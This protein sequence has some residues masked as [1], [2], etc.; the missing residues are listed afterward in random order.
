MWSPRGRHLPLVGARS[1][2]TASTCSEPWC[3]PRRLRQAAQ[4]G[5]SGAPVGAPCGAGGARI[6]RPERCMLT[7]RG[8]RDGSTASVPCSGRQSSPGTVAS[9]YGT[10][11]AGAAE[12]G[13]EVPSTL[14]VP[15]GRQH[16][17]PL[18]IGARFDP[19]C[20]LTPEVVMEIVVV[21]RHTEVQDR[22]RKHAAEKLS[23]VAQL[24]PYAQRIDVEVT[25]GGK[26]RLCD[27]AERVELTVKAKGPVVRAEASAQDRYA[28]LDLATGKLLERLRRARDRR[29]NHKGRTASPR[30]AEAP[31]PPLP[32]LE[33]EPVPEAEEI[34]RQI[35]RASCRERA[36]Q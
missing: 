32:D 14:L 10:S 20:F 22:F 9:R 33:P 13:D 6:R 12:G 25:R 8:L 16:S 26:R 18:R 29:K 15:S 19:E 34:E 11:I 21:S 23:K 35:G 1:R 31:I 28:A 17:T 4:P 36:G 2:P 24:S 3:W 30:G 27:N 7:C 5:S